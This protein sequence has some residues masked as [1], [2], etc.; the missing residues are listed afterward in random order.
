VD[1]AV[2][3]G[4]QEVEAVIGEE[5]SGTRD[6]LSRLRLAIQYNEKK[7]FSFMDTLRGLVEKECKKIWICARISESACTNS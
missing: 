3:R 4:T 7:V 6:P 5:N 1:I 2:C